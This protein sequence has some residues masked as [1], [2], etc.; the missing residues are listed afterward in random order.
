M[1]PKVLPVVRLLLC[2]IHKNPKVLLG[3]A[4]LSCSMAALLHGRNATELCI[5]SASTLCG[6]ASARQGGQHAGGHGGRLHA[7]A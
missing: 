6:C 2:S 4:L 3:R 7:D 5:T 1:D